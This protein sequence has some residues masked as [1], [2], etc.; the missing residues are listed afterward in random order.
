MVAKHQFDCI[1]LKDLVV[2]DKRVAH[3]G[4]ELVP[5]D[6]FPEMSVRLVLGV[7]VEALDHLLPLDEETGVEGHVSGKEGLLIFVVQFFIAL[8]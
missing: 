3:R 6:E 7:S 8:L 2:G 1:L 5:I 4:P